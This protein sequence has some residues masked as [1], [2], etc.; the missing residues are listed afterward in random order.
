LCIQSVSGDGLRING[1]LWS[2]T[3]ALTT[4][5]VLGDWCNKTVCDLLADDFS[6]L[7][8][9]QPE[10]IILGTGKRSEFPPRELTFAFARRGIGLEVMNTDAAARTFNVL[11]SEDRKVAAVLYQ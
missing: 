4:A 6:S 5:R 9:Y 11:A 1:Q 3:V 7:L 8:E 10:L 2:G